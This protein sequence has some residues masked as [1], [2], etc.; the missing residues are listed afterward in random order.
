MHVVRRPKLIDDLARAYEWVAVN[1]FAAAER[2]LGLVDAAVARLARFPYIGAPREEL[3]PGLRSIRIRPFPHLL[4]YS[5][6]GETVTLIRLL[7]GARDLPNQD[8][9][10]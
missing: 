6:D 3:G 2:L 1:D 7:H 10:E 5:V 8:L 4:F 9:D